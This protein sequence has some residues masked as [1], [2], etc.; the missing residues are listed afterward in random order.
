MRSWGGCLNGESNIPNLATLAIENGFPIIQNFSINP[1]NSKDTTFT[2]SYCQGNIQTGTDSNINISYSVG[3]LN[4]LAATLHTH[5][6]IGYAAQSAYDIYALIEISMQNSYYKGGF[7]AAANGS[8][9]AVAITDKTLA[10]AFLNKKANNLNGTKWNENSAIGIAYND[11]YKY[12]SEKVYNGNPNQINLAYEMAMATTLNNTG[13]TLF[14]QDTNG[15][16]KP[17][18]VNRTSTI[19]GSGIFKR[20]VA[21]YTQTCN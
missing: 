15:N 17:I 18:V 13:V 7:V 2:N 20:T 11:A 10:A 5:P 21:T 6:S 3:Y 1:Y 8:K 16:F 9:Y 14:K 12:Y 19:K 4:V